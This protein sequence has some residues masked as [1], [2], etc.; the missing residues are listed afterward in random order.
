MSALQHDICFES[1]LLL[2]N[3]ASLLPQLLVAISRRNLLGMRDFI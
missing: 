2:T 1:R 3:F